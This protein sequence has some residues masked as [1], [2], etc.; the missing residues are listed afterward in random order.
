MISISMLNICGDLI[1]KPLVLIFKS[2]IESR[3]FPIEWK[4]A[5]LVP[6]NE[7]SNKQV[8]EIDRP[9]SLLAVCGKTLERISY[10]KMF[11]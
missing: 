8:I 7:K 11:E 3:K 1:F 9:I 2:F 10:K 5:N 4:K 6:V